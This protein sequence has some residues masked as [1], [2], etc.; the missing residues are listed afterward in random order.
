MTDAM[1]RHILNHE[2]NEKKHIG[3]PYETM[4]GILVFSPESFPTLMAFAQTRHCVL[5][6]Q[7]KSRHLQLSTF[8][9]ITII[10]F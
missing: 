6:E 9:G 5:L 3:F 1:W 10:T 7:V 2:L 8:V 4:L